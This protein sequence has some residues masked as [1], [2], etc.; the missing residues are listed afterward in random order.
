MLKR[1][2]KRRTTNRRKGTKKKER[3]II[4]WRSSLIFTLRGKQTSR[5]ISKQDT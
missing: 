4:Q 5:I 2:R 3:K 1:R